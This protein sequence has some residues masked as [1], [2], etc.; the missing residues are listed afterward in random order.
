MLLM[1]VWAGLACVTCRGGHFPPQRRRCAKLAIS[2]VSGLVSAPASTS[3]ARITSP[4]SVTGGDR[5]A[6]RCS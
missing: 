2:I 5:S 3:I 6:F 1:R 4:R